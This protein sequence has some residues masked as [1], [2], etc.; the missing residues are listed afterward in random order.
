MNEKMRQFIR[1][2]GQCKNSFWSA[3]KLAILLMLLIFSSR[4]IVAQLA[5]A[6]ILGTVTDSTGAIIP[7]ANV[8]LI[9]LDTRDQRVAL[10]NDSGDFQFTLLPVGHYSL[11]VKA[12]GFKTTTTSLAVEAGD[13]ARADIHLITGGATETIVV[14]A[15]TPLLQADNATVSSTVTSQ[16]VQDLPL[17]GRNFVQLVQLVPG[18]NEGPG[19]GLTSGGRPDDRRS[20]NGFSVNGQ[21]DTLNNYVVDG[22]DDNERVIGTIGVKPSVEGIQEITVQTNS[23]APEAGRT[24]GGVINLVTKSGSNQFHGTLYEFIRNDTFDGRDWFATTGKKP[25]LRQN[26]YG[27]SIGGPIIRN[28]T[29]F[30]GD[31]E[32]L[33]VV[34]GTT[35]TSTVPTLTE[36]N[37][38]NSQNGLTPAGLMAL[39]NGTT[40]AGYTTPDPVALAYLRLFPAPNV[41]STNCPTLNCYTIS[42]NKTQYSHTYDA[43]VDH[44]FS[45]R[46]HF[47]ARF[48]Y[49][50]VT[51]TIPAY[52]PAGANPLAPSALK[53]IAGGGNYWAYTGPAKDTAQQ[54][55]LGYTHLF[56]Q[57]LVADL[58]A[59]Y[60]RVNNFSQPQNYNTNADTT[61]GFAANGLSSMTSAL[62]PA[63]I[64][65]FS[66]L[67]DGAYVPLQDIDNTFQYSGT[68]SYTLGN[69]SLKLGAGLIR[70]QA[71]NLQSAFPFGH[72]SG[73]GLSTDSGP[74]QV[75][76]SMLAGAFTG[77]SYNIDLKTP[78]Y[79]TW[80]PSFFAQD[81][82]KFNSKL[83]VTYGV[84]YD[85]FTPFTEAHNHISNF[86]YTT[87]FNAT[88][89]AAAQAALQVAGV[90][91]VSDKA[92][93]NTTYTDFAPRLGFSYS[94][95]PT[96]VFRGGYGISYFPGN[97]TS[98][99]DL[100]NAPF[101][102]VYSPSCQSLAAYNI[103][104]AAGS[105]A[106]NITPACNGTDSPNT[107]DVGLPTPTPQTINSL[108]LSFTAE[109]PKDKPS[110][111]QQYNLQIEKQFG[112]NVL[113]VGYVGNIGQ[114]L[115][116][117]IGDINDPTPTQVKAKGF[118]TPRPLSGSSPKGP[119]TGVLPNVGQVQWL[120]SEGISNYNGLQTSFQRRFSSGL[121]FDANYT[122]GH[123]LSDIVG[124]SEEGHQGWADAD[125]TNIRKI[126]YGNA[127]NDIRNR[128]ALS[129]NYE[130]PFKGFKGPE[131]LAFEGWQVNSIVAWQSGKPFSIFNN[132][133]YSV[134]G[135]GYNNWA[136]PQFNGGPDRPNQVGDPFKAGPVAANPGCSAP[137]QVKTIQNWINPCAYVPQSL[138]TVGSTARN[139]VYGPHFRHI[140]FSLFK[141]FPIFE[142]LKLQFRAEAFNITNTPSFY[143]NNNIHSS[144]GG[145]SNSAGNKFGKIVSTDPNYVPRQLQ[146]ALKLQ[147]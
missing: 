84:R 40:A 86:D 8:T 90:N 48:N 4:Q 46:D 51:G 98:N 140:D 39:G 16:S 87:A 121:A 43:R 68:V 22:I 10:S 129:I 81:N 95:K 85:V 25:E 1:C 50:K 125:P 77:S 17:N 147:F 5:T 97:Y 53:S 88:S 72:Y 109:D 120:T 122:W 12:T 44:T 15:S 82:W 71:R 145:L 60:T 117:V 35:Y 42:P 136:T 58:R 108:N 6:D 37:Y 119:S 30:F 138:G 96:M 36:Y 134:N 91:G 23:Y 135:T 29:F 101:T 128:F 59:A 47:F 94:L 142:G 61:V 24:A 112:P 11:T 14:E 74:D 114:H 102:S 26:Q 54:W 130:L 18:A 146:F 79:R 118:N 107:L 56:S 28:K 70:R 27:G 127:E 131:K 143:L 99:A 3:G 34:K 62:T 63:D 83:T 20:T 31:Y 32:G 105:N 124:F 113:T 133:G 45:Q 65:D 144:E 126:E 78:D 110:L 141:D 106:A 116:E 123:A 115:P 21:D 73:F 38:I 89:T 132:S 93:I 139:S 67:G 104:I 33:R 57:N 75:L 69:H 49:N 76:A 13:R 64:N 103:L 66:S 19:N 41:S 92:G 55:A 9:N 2:T 137:S 7:K 111:I 52:L 100:K 80:E